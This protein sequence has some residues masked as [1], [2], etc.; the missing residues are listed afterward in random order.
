MSLTA[1]GRHEK[2]GLDGFS[3]P[4]GGKV[5]MLCMVVVVL[6]PSTHHRVRERWTFCMPGRLQP[7][8]GCV[9]ECWLRRNHLDQLKEVR[10]CDTGSTCSALLDQTRL[11][12]TAALANQ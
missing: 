10:K 2:N 8:D 11:S 3:P 6:D 7:I 9:G 1:N 5:D 4:L 12:T